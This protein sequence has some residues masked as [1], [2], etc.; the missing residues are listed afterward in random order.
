M[1]MH[2]TTKRKNK[3]GKTDRT[4]ERIVT[5]GNFNIPL[6]WMLDQTGRKS[7]RMTIISLSRSTW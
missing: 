7:I 1:F 6:S 4:E 2:Q 5:V 3:W